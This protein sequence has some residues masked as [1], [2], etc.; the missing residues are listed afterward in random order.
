MSNTGQLF[1]QYI[2]DYI[3]NS[4][5]SNGTDEWNFINNNIN[6]YNKQVATNGSYKSEI[7]QF[8]F[9]QS[10]TSQKNPNF[11]KKLGNSI[12]G[13]FNSTMNF[14]NENSDSLKDLG[15]G[16]N[17][18]LPSNLSDLTGKQAGIKGVMDMGF[19]AAENIPIAG[20]FIKMGNTANA[21]MPDFLAGG[22]G[23]DQLVNSI[24]GMKLL[25]FSVGK[26]KDFGLNEQVQSSGYCGSAAQI[27][28]AKNDAGKNVGAITAMF[29]NKKKL[30]K[31]INKA[32]Q[33]QDKVDDLLTEGNLALDT[34]AEMADNVAL[35]NRFEQSGGW[36]GSIAVGKK[37]LKLSDKNCAAQVLKKKDTNNEQ[38]FIP[39]GALHAHRHSLK[40]H[41]ETLAD[42]VTRKGV[43]VVTF[44]DGGEIEQH[45]EIER[46]EIIFRLEISQKL[47]ELWK[48]GSEE[49][50]IEAGK[51]IAEEVVTNTKD[52]SGEYD[53][54][55]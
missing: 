30:N 31:K 49:A 2:G 33:T 43:P 25:N 17:S 42:S 19:K 48:D 9:S 6:D 28:D 15:F 52:K 24:P 40:S 50:M 54:K 27:S 12:S 10:D 36:S 55:D 35:E 38:S 53:I 46:G 11:F 1:N 37:G 18:F 39:G 3:S 22:T 45:A 16:I 34:Q 47:E 7:S 41:D 8:D 4:Q 14:M 21:L 13:G 26:T 23:K 32:I 20:S 5:P 51:L 29:G 44:E